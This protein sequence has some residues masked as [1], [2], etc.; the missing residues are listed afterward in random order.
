M[1]L[2]QIHAP[3]F[4]PGLYS[5]RFE[6]RTPLPRIPLRLTATNGDIAP[7]AFE[8]SQDN[9]I[10]G[11][12]PRQ[13]VKIEHQTISREHARLFQRDG[14][15]QVADLNSSNGTFVNGKKVSRQAVHHGDLIRFG[16]LEFQVDLASAQAPSAQAPSAPT[17]SDPSEE[18]IFG[19][20][21]S[22]PSKPAPAVDDDDD[23]GIV[24]EDPV[25]Q[26]PA[27]AGE[28]PPITDQT[29]IVQPKP[30]FRGQTPGPASGASRPKGMDHMTLKTRDSSGG[31]GGSVLKQDVGQFGGPRQILMVIAAV[32]ICAVLFYLVM[33]MTESVVPEGGIPDAA[34]ID[35]E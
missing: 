32:A 35:D 11:R 12:L 26:P 25:L 33:Q 9:V 14:T 28:A 29:M 4:G 2:R 31:S 1:S 19:D 34:P 17:S 21:P 30:M 6:D 23:G 10:L 27:G 3:E 24:L 8:A 5:V 7:I 16:E 15:W 20:S 22:T 13:G 18:D